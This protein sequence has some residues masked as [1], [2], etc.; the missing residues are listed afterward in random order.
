MINSFTNLLNLIKMAK[1]KTTT[2][3]R[4]ATNVKPA[5][6]TCTITGNKFEANT[7]NF[8]VNRNATDGLHPYH[9]SIDNFRRTT[10]ASVD[11]VRKL[12]T[13]IKG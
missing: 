6:K 8:Y 3:T 4:R 12:V 1:T 9:K 13:M 2:T 11:Q 7:E 5:M 10:N